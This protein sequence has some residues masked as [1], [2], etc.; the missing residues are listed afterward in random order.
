[1]HTFGGKEFCIKFPVQEKSNDSESELSAISNADNKCIVEIEGDI[2]GLTKDSLELYLESAKKSGGG[3]VETIDLD[4]NPPRV[5]FID[6]EGNYVRF[7]PTK[8]EFSELDYSLCVVIELCLSS[9]IDIV[10]LSICW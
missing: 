9:K 5:V 6:P 4:A 3:D 7:D 2:G 10:L 1:M 8:R